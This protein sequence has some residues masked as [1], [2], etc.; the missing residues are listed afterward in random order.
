MNL[1]SFKQ[2][3]RNSLKGKWGTAILASLI[4]S[5]LG[6]NGSIDLN[7]NSEESQ[8]GSGFALGAFIIGV[9]F[10]CLGKVINAGYQK[11]NLDLVDGMPCELGTLFTYFKH[12]KN[13]ILTNLLSSLYIF[14]WSLLFIIPG[15]VAAYKYAMVPYILA[16]NPEMRPRE[17][18]EMSEEM[19]RGNKWRLFCLYF[20]FIGWHL[21]CLLSVGIG[22]IW[23][24]PYINASVADFYREV[25]GTRFFANLTTETENV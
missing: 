15:I 9:L 6:S 20:S 18:L 17:A 1:S 5:L 25:S 13:L 12:W 8:I 7:F 2:N 23:L 16:E 22:Y 19:M 4:A 10:Y 3:A 21:L 11:F 14:L 24:I